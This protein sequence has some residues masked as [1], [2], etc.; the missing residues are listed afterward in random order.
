MHE[1]ID[2]LEY[3]I[4][5]LKAAI[6]N[7]VRP[8][9]VKSF[10]PAR[11]TAKLDIGVDGDGTHDIP[12]GANHAH[13]GGQHWTG[14]SEGMQVTVF[15]PEG[16]LANAFFMPGGYRD[17]VTP[18][19]TRADE[20]VIARDGGAKVHVRKGGFIALRV[21]SIEKLKIQ[22]GDAW[23]QLDPA[24]LASTDPLET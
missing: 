14:I 6:C 10:D 1:R 12:N 23:F 15:A 17:G 19:S 18:P 8:G 2:A 9:T 5:A 20:D 7:L 13:A 11:N 16:D 24:A 4:A 21:P 22:I 3:E